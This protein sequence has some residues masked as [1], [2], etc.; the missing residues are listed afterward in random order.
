MIDHGLDLAV[1]GNCRTAALVNPMSRLVWWC[2]PNFDANPMFSRLVAG[3]EEKGFSDVVLDNL[4]DYQSEYRPQH[5]D[6][7]DH[8]DRRARQRRQDHRFR[9]AL[10]AIRP[11]V[12]PGAAVPHHRA[13]Q[14]P[15]ADHDPGPA[16][17][18]L[19][20]AVYATS[21]GSNHIRYVEGDAAMR[22]T[23]DAPLSL[24]QN[25]TPFVIT[26]PLHLVF[27]PD[28]PFA[29][30]LAATARTSPSRRATTGATGC[31]A[32]SSPMSGRKRSSAP[33]SR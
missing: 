20:Q 6:R 26:R 21:L 1:I 10:P 28:E 17:P 2:F 16:D 30:D 7:I 4:A 25:E 29:G 14:G 12:P 15:A 23:T 32:C 8:P 19:R 22:V 33:R 5:R 13:D 31:G 11:D 9:A 3:D 27:G 18:F 24:I